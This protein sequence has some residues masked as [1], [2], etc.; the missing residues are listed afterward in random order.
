M[1]LIHVKEI[2]IGFFLGMVA[3]PGIPAQ[4]AAPMPTVDRLH[5]GLTIITVENIDSPVAALDIWIRHGSADDPKGASGTAHLL[6]H[7]L[8]KGSTARSRA[9]MD[10]IVKAMGGY[11]NGATSLDFTHYYISVPSDRAEEALA[12]LA[13]AVLTPCL[14]PADLDGER[15]VVMEEIRRKADDPFGNLFETCLSDLFSGTSYGRTT[16]GTV[17][18]LRAVDMKA[19]KNYYQSF[20]RPEEMALVATGGIKRD[21][22]IKMAEQLFGQ[23]GTG[24]REGRG[25]LVDSVDITSMTT[26]KRLT[27]PMAV[28]QAYIIVACPVPGFT[29]GK[30][31]RDIYAL[32]VLAAVLGQGKASR[33]YKTLREQKGL[34]SEVGAFNMTLNRAGL[35]VAYAVVHPQDVKRVEEELRR[36]LIEHDAPDMAEMS[37]AKALIRRDYIFSCEGAVATAGLYGRNWVSGQT[38][39]DSYLQRIAEIKPE[40]IKDAVARY[41]TTDKLCIYTVMPQGGQK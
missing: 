24:N 1:R 19:L 28:N 26:G 36:M 27:L 38:G 15:Q 20:Y 6:E 34:A 21:R 32:D 35:M 14:D 30:S 25:R 37:R 7:M 31:S 16:L 13:E 10:G 41:L 3:L 39:A 29:G 8:F 33:L 18:D 23:T 12:L 4:A 40:D 11:N 2:V 9:E 5:N 17:S 22:I